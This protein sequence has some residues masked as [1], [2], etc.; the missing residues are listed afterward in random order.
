MERRY[1]RKLGVI[2]SNSW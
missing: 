2:R 1:F